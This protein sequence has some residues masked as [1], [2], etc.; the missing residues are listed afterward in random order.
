MVP[1]KA[2]NFSL[3]W[4]QVYFDISVHSDNDNLQVH[5][6][7]VGDGLKCPFPQS[8][9]ALSLLPSQAQTPSILSVV[10]SPVPLL[11]PKTL[12]SRWVHIQLRSAG[13]HAQW[14]TLTVA[15]RVAWVA[16][17]QTARAAPPRAACAPSVI[18]GGQP[19]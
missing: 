10:L 9:T 13:K 11:R 6:R 17:A 15:A 16:P 2:L 3:I 14:I 18:G 7:L 12:V 4:H 19:N 5:V 1:S 8:H